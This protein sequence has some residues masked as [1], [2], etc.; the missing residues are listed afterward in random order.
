MGRAQHAGRAPLTSIC[1]RTRTEGTK[2]S[3]QHGQHLQLDE[4]K[5]DHTR[6]TGLA[7]VIRRN[8][9]ALVDALRHPASCTQTHRDPAR[10]AH[11]AQTQR[12]PASCGHTQATE[13]PCARPGYALG[14]LTSP[15]PPQRCTGTHVQ[16]KSSASVQC[17]R[18]R[19]P[20][21]R[22]AA[23]H[24]PAGQPR[25]PGPRARMPGPPPPPSFP[26]RFSRFQPPIPFFG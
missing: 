13:L 14:R 6:E 3:E 12:W 25:P 22:H 20:G 9:R 21:L 24:T 16:A 10:H 8:L 19:S 5:H 15:A 7:G 18:S 17:P 1:A 2:P 23:T 26:C 11:A 4:G